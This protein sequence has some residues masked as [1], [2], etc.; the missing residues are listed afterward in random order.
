M[1]NPHEHSTT[2]DNLEDPTIHNC[3]SHVMVIK[4]VEDAQ[5]QITVGYFILFFIYFSDTE[6]LKPNSFLTTIHL[7]SALNQK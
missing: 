4:V 1:S 3:L 6:I 5:S 2:V 7:M